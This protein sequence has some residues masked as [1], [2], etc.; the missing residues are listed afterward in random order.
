[1]ERHYKQ[2]GIVERCEISRLHK[3]GHSKR[4]IAEALHRSPSTI[5]RE[6]KR[7]CLG[8]GEYEPAEA[9]MIALSKRWKG[10]KLD[11]DDKLRNTVLDLLKRGWSPEQ[12]AGHLKQ[13]M[14]RSVVSYETIYRFIY[15]QVARMKDYSWRHYL[16]RKKARRGKRGGRKRRGF[17]SI[18]HRCPISKRPEEVDKRKTP[19][20]WEADTMLFSTYSQVILVLHERYT[21]LLVAMRLSG[22]TSESIVDA[23][24]KMLA[25]L[26]S[27]WRQTVTFD[28]GTEFAKHYR[29]HELGIQTF[30]CDTH[31][32]WQN[33]GVENATLDA[34]VEYSPERVDPPHFQPFNSR[35]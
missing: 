26:P 1:M 20:H 5:T 10:S 27:M 4:K 21:R 9:N 15:K 32:P 6:I 29:L 33:G 30:F 35:V 22:K 16:P 24:R 18:T 8:E 17:A 28:N 34:C 3:E 7:N 13:E 14:G 19:G 12:V 23:I 31:S 11:R 25:T 2:L